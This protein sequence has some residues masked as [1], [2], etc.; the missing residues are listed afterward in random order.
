MASSEPEYDFY[1]ETSARAHARVGM[2]VHGVALVALA[3]IHFFILREVGPPFSWAVW[4]FGPLFLALVLWSFAAW[5]KGGDY[6][7]FIQNGKLTIESP[8]RSMFGESNEILISEIS[9]LVI[10]AT[11]NEGVPDRHSII[12]VDGSRIQLDETWNCLPFLNATKLFRAITTHDRRI[13]VKVET[14]K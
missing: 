8:D 3:V 1:H 4:I 2:M 9:A 10:N 14:A 6:R 5:K 12:L 7:A 11:G 13:P